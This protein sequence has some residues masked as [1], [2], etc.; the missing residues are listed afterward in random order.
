MVEDIQENRLEVLLSEAYLVIMGY[1]AHIK[2]QISHI[3]VI[4]HT[5]MSMCFIALECVNKRMNNIQQ[6]FYAVPVTD[7]VPSGS[8]I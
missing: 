5:K 7:G 3:H 8:T 6:S 2:E 4:I 1:K